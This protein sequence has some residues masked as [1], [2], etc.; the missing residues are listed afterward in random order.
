MHAQSESQRNTEEF[1]LPCWMERKC[2][3]PTAFFEA[4]P[5]LLILHGIIIL[6]IF[7]QPAGM[8]AGLPLLGAGL[9]AL[10]IR[11]KQK[12]DCRKKKRSQANI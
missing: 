2:W 11:A 7:E 6:L 4:V 1:L 5:Y 9:L 12:C 10:I 8:M 3:W